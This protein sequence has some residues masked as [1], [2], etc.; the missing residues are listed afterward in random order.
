M[1]KAKYEADHTEVIFKGQ[2]KSAF[3][4]KSSTGNCSEN[5]KKTNN[6][7]DHLKACTRL[8]SANS[9]S[10]TNAWRT[11]M[12]NS[13]LEE[14]RNMCNLWHYLHTPSIQIEKQ[15]DI[16]QTLPMRNKPHFKTWHSVTVTV[17]Y[18]LGVEVES[19]VLQ[20]STSTFQ[21]EKHCVSRAKTLRN[22]C[23]FPHWFHSDKNH[24]VRVVILLAR[25]PAAALFHKTRR[26]ISWGFVPKSESV[27][28]R[29][30]IEMGGEE[31]ERWRENRGK[32][33]RSPK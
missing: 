29:S 13:S 31:K 16:K 9:W 17:L 19:T 6:F 30:D 18:V 12:L 25:S 15:A 23:R 5:R 22:V 11:L 28:S 20:P 10:S 27:Q 33:H 3:F 4:T 24:G 2:T 26:P 14:R 32:T 1:E 7:E 8:R 21:T